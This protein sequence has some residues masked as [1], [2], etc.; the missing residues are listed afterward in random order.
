MIKVEV[1]KD[2][3]YGE[4][5][6]I[7]ASLKRGTV[8]ADEGALYVTDTFECDK[9][10]ADYLLGNNPIKEPVV[11][12][13]EVEPEEKPIPEDK[14]EIIITSEKIKPTKKKKNKK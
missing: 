5:D 6:K 7:K 11:K 4:F 14:P 12:I 10:A 13:V 9:K 8:K 2:F 3:R 1:I